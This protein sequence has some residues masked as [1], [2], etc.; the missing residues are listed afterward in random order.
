[1]AERYF[2]YGSNLSMRQMQARCPSARLL[3]R[4]SLQDWRLSFVQP[5]E[6]WRGG[7]AGIVQAAG[8][9]VHGVIYE[10]SN[11]DLIRLDGFE[12][13]ESGSYK[14]TMTRAQLSTDETLECW[15]Y[16][17]DV[18]P[19]APFAPSARYLQTMLTGAREHG[20]PEDYIDWIAREFPAATPDLRHG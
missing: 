19:G 12:P 8:G 10:L 17:G 16:I 4:C 2:A 9:I 18:Y 1:L 13:V 5:H 15:V 3:C 6:G 11:E 14:R 20:L 7:V